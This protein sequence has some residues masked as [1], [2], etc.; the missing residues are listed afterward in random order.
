MNMI[1]F[2]LLFILFTSAAH[3]AEI[4][5]AQAV[6][7]LMGEARGESYEA[8][9][10]HAEAYRNRYAR[11]GRVKG[12]FGCTAK[13]SEPA[14]VWARVKKAWLESANTNLVNGATHWESTDFK[15]PS[16]SHGAVVT[17]KFGK[18]KFYKGVR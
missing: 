17:A 11:Y 18:T 15:V 1:R 7:C 16:W 5:E 2:L 12:V 3:A 14:R 6:R 4:N 13:F 9:V 10:A 8:I